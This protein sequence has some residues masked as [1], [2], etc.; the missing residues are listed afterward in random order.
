MT[1][2]ALM[3]NWNRYGGVVRSN[4]AWWGGGVLYFTPLLDKG[5]YCLAKLIQPSR[6]KAI[7][8]IYSL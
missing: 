1:I 3:K 2:I 7:K 8:A 4:A 6:R 5:I